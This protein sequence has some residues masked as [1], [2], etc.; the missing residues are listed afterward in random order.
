[1]GAHRL[2]RVDPESTGAAF[3]VDLSWM[4]GLEVRPGLERYGACA[5]FSADGKLLR[6]YTPHDDRSQEAGSATWDDAKWRWR[7]SL[8]TAVTVADHLG[9]THFLVSNLVAT[10]YNV[11]LP[12]DHMLRRLLKPFCYRTAAVN[13]DAALALAPDGGLDIGAF[14]FTYDGLT[15]A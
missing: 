5:Y 11:Q 1:M 15:F 6:I 7:T 2:A 9:T 10:A 14:A 4:A 12:A 8:F 3:T 13:S